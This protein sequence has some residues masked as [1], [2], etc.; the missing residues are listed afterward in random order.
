M[1]DRSSEVYVKIELKDLVVAVKEITDWYGLGL[2]LCLPVNILDKIRSN[3]DIDSHM[4]DMLHAW[5]QHDPEASWEK[6][7]TALATIDKNMV[8]D[9][10]RARYMDINAR[11]AVERSRHD[12]KKRKFFIP[13]ES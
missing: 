8:A 6:L 2:Q 7:A 11:Q 13:P 5:L 10:I 4:R 9:N 12:E 3:P 1:S